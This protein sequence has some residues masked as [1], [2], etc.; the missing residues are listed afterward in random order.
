MLIERDLRRDL[1]GG[2]LRRDAVEEGRGDARVPRRQDGMAAKE[3]GVRAAAVQRRAA[4][5]Q[6]GAA[7]SRP[8][9]WRELADG[10]PTVVDEVRR[11]ARKGSEAPKTKDHRL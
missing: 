1:A 3:A 8:A 6:P 7:V 4:D 9:R 5:Q 11:G 10:G 2:D